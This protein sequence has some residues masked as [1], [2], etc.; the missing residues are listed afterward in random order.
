MKPTAI[1]VNTSRGPVVDTPAL[2]E[3]LKTHKI[4]GAALDVTDPEPI[5]VDSSLT[6]MPNVVITPHIA[7]ASYQ[8]RT[9]MSVI[10]TENLIAGIK[11]E[12][13][14]YCANPEVYQQL[15]GK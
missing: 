1:L 12:K 2:T 4:G 9:R 8:T 7:S 15:K 3:A 11:G 6:Q 10:A 14:Q 5:P 13:L